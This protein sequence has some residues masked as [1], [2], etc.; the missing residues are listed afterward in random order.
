MAIEYAKVL[1]AQGVPFV[2]VTR[3][4]SSASKF[5]LVT[6]MTALTG[7]L[8]HF[9]LGNPSI[10]K[11]A[12]VATGIESLASVTESL[13]HYGVTSILVEKPAGVDVQQI[14]KT[15]KLAERNN[16]NVFV[17]YNR[18][19]Y[20]SVITAKKMIAEDGGATSLTYEITEWSHS[21]DKLDID[22]DSK[23][24]WFIA[25]TSHVVD[26]AFYL[27]GQPIELAAYTAGSTNWH[28]R[29]AIFAGSGITANGALFSY[30]GNWNSPGRWSVD[31]LTQKRRYIFRPM[32][33]LH[34]QEIGS[35]AINRID[36][37]VQYD[38]Q[39]K[40]GLYCQMAAFLK[41]E[42]TQLCSITEH[43]EHLEF[44]TKM[45]NY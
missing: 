32:E 20:E 22:K 16:A 7:G 27:G 25:N 37:Q 33:E 19:F 30:A 28:D 39:F 38:Q 3:S 4:E 26:L 13:L 2:C 17:A 1:N 11:H 15:Q 18:R 40:P 21:I 8:E 29:S 31:I 9:L 6:G 23:R 44:Y 24:N 42:Y 34:V 14:E 45:A 10:P 41:A 5:M 36:L 35:T 12:I 43:R